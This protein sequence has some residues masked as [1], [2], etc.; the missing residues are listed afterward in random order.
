MKKIFTSLMIVSILAA[1]TVGV[2]MAEDETPSYPYNGPRNRGSAEN[3]IL[4]S[5]MQDALVDLLGITEEEYDA[6]IADGYN[7]FDIA[8]DLGIDA[9]TLEDLRLQAREDAIAAALADGVIPQERAQAFQEMSGTG[10]GLGNCF[11]YSSEYMH[12]FAGEGGPGMGMGGG[13]Q[14]GGQNGGQYGPGDGTGDG[15]CDGTGAL[16][17][18][19]C[20]GDGPKGPMGP[21][22]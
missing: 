12:Q 19:D 1:L 4:A 15:I 13:N 17:T 20:D 16:G 22:N 18:G 3:R 11:Q 7:L 5:Y 8:A 10:F 14:F 2:V 21:K 6:Y 9:E